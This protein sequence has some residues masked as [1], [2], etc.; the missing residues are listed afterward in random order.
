[1]KQDQ[2]AFLQS[3][4]LDVLRVQQTFIFSGIEA[5]SRPNSKHSLG[6][7]PLG[8]SYTMRQKIST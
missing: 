1:M 6:N 4:G 3:Y 2:I 5:S 8:R 7:L